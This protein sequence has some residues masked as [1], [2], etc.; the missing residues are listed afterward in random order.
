MGQA[1]TFYFFR[2]ILPYESERSDNG[3]QE[4]N[5]FYVNLLHMYFFTFKDENYF[6]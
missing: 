4:K 3:K 6:S 2:F 1:T 5:H